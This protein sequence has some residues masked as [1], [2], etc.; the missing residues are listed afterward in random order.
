MNPLRRL[1]ELG[2]APL[3]GPLQE[4]NGVPNIL[5][6]LLLMKNGFYA[7]ESSLHVYPWGGGPGSGEFWNDPRLWREEYGDAVAG[8]TFFAEDAFGFQFATDGDA[9]FSFDPEVAERE[10]VSSD[11]MEWASLILEDFEVRTGFPVMHEWQVHNGRIL[12]GHRLA[13][14]TPFFL[15]GKYEAREMRMME[16]VGLMRFRANV[17]RQVKDLPDGAKVRIVVDWDSGES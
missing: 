14:A 5:R 11:V 16:S 2:S 9:I 6:P 3:G 13:P 12:H 10:R 15:G 7:F 8:L 1:A 4:Q 17:Y